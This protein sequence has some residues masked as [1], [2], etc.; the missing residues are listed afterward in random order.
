MKRKPIGRYLLA[1][2][3]AALAMGLLVFSKEV[4][5]GIR[6]GMERCATVLIPS[7]FPFMVLS[8]FLS[9]AEV[10]TVLARPLGWISERCF[11]LPRD[12]GILVLLSFIGGYPVGARMVSSLYSQRRIEKETAERMLCFCVNA[13]PSFVISAVGAGMLQDK[14]AG[15]VLLCSQVCASLLVGIASARGAKVP[16]QRTKSPYM[17][18]VPAFVSAVAAAATSML[19]LCGF[20]VLFAGANALLQAVRIPGAISNLLGLEQQLVEIVLSGMLEVTGGCAA[21]AALGGGAGVGLVA[22]FLSFGGLSVCFQVMA[23]FE[24][25]ALSFRKFFLM[26]ILHIAVAVS[27]AVPLYTRFCKMESAWAS[28]TPPAAQR[29]GSTPV[30]SLCLIAMCT[31]FLLNQRDDGGKL[32]KRRE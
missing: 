7:L 16:R 22:A 18:P 21:A 5:L 32:H 30:L 2:V 10:S 31:I 29:W 26:R 24:D 9:L 4:G 20:A 1:G 6:F 8:I 17:A 27:M 19:H 23:M 12:M 14:V 13:G 3:I 11:A 25:R 15:V 28:S